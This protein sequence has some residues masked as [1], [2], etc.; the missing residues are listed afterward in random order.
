VATCTAPTVGRVPKP[1]DT[2]LINVS[3]YQTSS[4]VNEVP[5]A[6]HF[7]QGTTP[8]FKVLR[9]NSV[10]NRLEYWTPSGAPPQ[11]VDPGPTSFTTSYIIDGS[12]LPG[13]WTVNWAI[14]S[15]APNDRYMILIGTEVTGGDKYLSIPLLVSS[16]PVAPIFDAAD[17]A[18]VFPYR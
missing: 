11:T 17:C 18:T 15:A 7:D 16:D 13:L 8:N 12:T 9:W 1:G 3:I 4:T 5:L 2:V 14:P 10:L 6:F